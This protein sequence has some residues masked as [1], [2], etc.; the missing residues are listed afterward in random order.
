[1]FRPPSEAGRYGTRQTWRRA[2]PDRR[3]SGAINGRRV[4]SGET[5][6]VAAEVVRLL[7]SRASRHYRP[8]PAGPTST[9]RRSP[10]A[11]VRT[12]RVAPARRA[13]SRPRPP[14]RSHSPC[15]RRRGGRRGDRRPCLPGPCGLSPPDL[16][17]PVG[18]PRGCRALPGPPVRCAQLAR[19]MT[20][21]ILR[22]SDHADDIRLRETTGKRHARGRS[23]APGRLPSASSTRRPGQTAEPAWTRPP[24]PRLSRPHPRRGERVRPAGGFAWAVRICCQPS[25][26]SEMSSPTR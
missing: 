1:M 7:A 23:P 21:R 9:R 18:P 5:D 2:R 19:V 20:K 16:W 3:R 22:T 26:R 13:A 15:D 17:N 8:Y 24:R 6:G 25:D 11:A 14:A 12:G 4:R 10:G